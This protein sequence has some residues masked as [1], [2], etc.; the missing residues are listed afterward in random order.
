M[1][2]KT[3]IPIPHLDADFKSQ[4]IEKLNE[5]G[6]Q[7]QG[8]SDLKSCSDFYFDHL[9]RQLYM[10]L[11]VSADQSKSNTGVIF[12]MTNGSVDVLWHQFILFTREYSAF[13][14]E[15]FGI[16]IHHAPYNTPAY[17]ER[18]RPVTELVDHIVDKFA[19]SESRKYLEREQRILWGIEDPE[20]IGNCG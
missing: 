6:E 3:S 7:R 14:E 17:K 10:F 2:V 18:V 15:H 12:P 9:W 13:C 5:E 19:T 16:F 8:F 1:S 4:L 11:S 20:I